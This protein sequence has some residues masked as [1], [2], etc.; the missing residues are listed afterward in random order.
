MPLRLHGGC[1]WSCSSVSCL[2]CDFWAHWGHFY[3]LTSEIIEN[4]TTGFPGGSNYGGHVSDV[5][6][7]V[8]EE[9]KQNV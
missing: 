2:S 7:N 6:S 3:S 1:V 4:V 5:Y 9:L 8:V